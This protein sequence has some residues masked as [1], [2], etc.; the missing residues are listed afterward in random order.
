LWLVGTPL[1]P[2]GRWFAFYATN[3]YSAATFGAIVS[4]LVTATVSRTTAKLPDEHV[5]ELLRSAR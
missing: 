4:L 2:F 5:R 3:P 1:E